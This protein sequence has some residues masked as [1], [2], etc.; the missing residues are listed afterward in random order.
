MAK[1]LFQVFHMSMLSL[2]SATRRSD[3]S[4]S[5]LFRFQVFCDCENTQGPLA[6]VMLG[7]SLSLRILRGSCQTDVTQVLSESVPLYYS[8]QQPFSRKRTL[9]LRAGSELGNFQL[10]I[11]FLSDLACNST[12]YEEA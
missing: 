11:D 12:G 5:Y 4:T 10:V 6:D 8:T 2:K 7:R 3:H 9:P 1:I